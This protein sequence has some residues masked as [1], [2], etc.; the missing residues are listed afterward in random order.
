M[1]LNSPLGELDVKFLIESKCTA[2]PL[3]LFY[4]GQKSVDYTLLDIFFLPVPPENLP[5]RLFFL[6]VF[7]VGFD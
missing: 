4:L 1:I 7:M 2:S 5:N 3:F 6:I